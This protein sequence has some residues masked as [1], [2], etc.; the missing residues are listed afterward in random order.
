MMIRGKQSI[1]RV[2]ARNVFNTLT[3]RL[4]S[5]LTNIAFSV[6]ACVLMYV[7]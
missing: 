1:G 3:Q 7:F 4:I 5:E 6:Y 2:S